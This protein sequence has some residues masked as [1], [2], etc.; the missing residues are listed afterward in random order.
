MPHAAD[1]RVE[2]HERP[3]VRDLEAVAGLDVLGDVLNDRLLVPRARLRVVRH[4]PSR[5]DLP[6]VHGHR[7]HVI[8]PR[9]DDSPVAVGVLLRDEALGSRAIDRDGHT[10]ISVLH[11]RQSVL[12]GRVN[13]ARE[14]QVHDFRHERAVRLVVRV[15]RVASRKVTVNNAALGVEVV[16]TQ[17]RA[18]HETQPSA[19]R[20]D[21]A[22]RAPLSDQ[23]YDVALHQFLEHVVLLGVEGLGPPEA[24][25]DVG[26]LDLGVALGLGDLVVDGGRRGVVLVDGLCG[27]LYWGG[28]EWRI[29]GNKGQEGQQLCTSQ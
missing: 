17:G 4:E 13:V 21:D 20:D 24:R 7:E 9:G 2:P 1:Q 26:V 3:D 15:A 12:A 6:E 29:V 28:R 25:D 10:K 14:A 18:Q 22:V 19:R 8:L 23:R 5:E 11:H 16:E 27:D